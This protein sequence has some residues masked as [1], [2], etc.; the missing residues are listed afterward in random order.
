MDDVDAL[1]AQVAD[2]NALE[3]A[4]LLPQVSARVKQSKSEEEEEEDFDDLELPSVPATKPRSML[5]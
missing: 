3:L 2:E 4:T 1:I 5:V